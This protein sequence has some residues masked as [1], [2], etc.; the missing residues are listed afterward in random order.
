MPELEYQEMKKKQA[1]A[2]AN[3]VN[4]LPEDGWFVDAYPNITMFL[5]D[6]VWDDGSPR[7][8]STMGISIKEGMFALALNDKDGRQSAYTS[9]ETLRDALAAMEAALEADRITW[10]PWDRKKK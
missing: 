5:T 9:A 8:P 2:A 10:R 1:K 4:A 7:D 6:T 3:G